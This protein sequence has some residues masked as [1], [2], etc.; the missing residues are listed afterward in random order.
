LEAY[1]AMGRTNQR[2]AGAV[3]HLI[4]SS[5]WAENANAVTRA[6]VQAS[7]K[8]INNPLKG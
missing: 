7:P 6:I 2:I 1:V 8:I 4:G 5:S 3:I